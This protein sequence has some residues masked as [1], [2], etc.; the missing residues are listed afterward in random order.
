MS[1][2]QMK[3]WAIP[4]VHWTMLTFILTPNK[5]ENTRTDFYKLFFFKIMKGKI[6]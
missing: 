2:K 5:I 3:M 4:P 1:V 6:Q